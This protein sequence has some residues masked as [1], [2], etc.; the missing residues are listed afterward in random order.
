[1]QAVQP[2]GCTLQTAKGRLAVPFF[3]LGVKMV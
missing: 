2:L 3:M 1:M